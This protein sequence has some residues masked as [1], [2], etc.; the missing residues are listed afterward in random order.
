MCTGSG[1]IAI[2]IKKQINCE[3]MA[4]DV[5]INALEV[6]KENAKLNDAKIDFI[7][8]N[9]FEN[10]NK[11]FDFILSNPPYIKT[12]DLTSLQDEVKREPTLALDGGDDGLDFYRILSKNA[13]KFLKNNG[14]LF[15]EI[16]C[17]QDEDVVKLFTNEHYKN[18]MVLS[19]LNG[20]KRIIKV[21]KND[22]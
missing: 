7:L 12:S 6:A 5:S 13:Y 2:A 22:D 3:M 19:D 16:G 11:T 18:I 20:I 4:V 9:A 8:S 17:G 15:M 1:A 14:K 21:V 10:V